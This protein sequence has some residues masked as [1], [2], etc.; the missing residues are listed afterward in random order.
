MLLLLPQ[1]MRADAMDDLLNFFYTYAVPLPPEESGLDPEW[2]SPYSGLMVQGRME[3]TSVAGAPL[4][5]KLSAANNGNVFKLDPAG[6]LVGIAQDGTKNNVKTVDG[7]VTRVNNS[8][9]DAVWVRWEDCKMDVKLCQELYDLPLRVQIDTS[10]EPENPTEEIWLQPGQ[11][12]N[13]ENN[14][15]EAGQN[16]LDVRPHIQQGQ[17]IINRTGYNAVYNV[18]STH[19]SPAIPK[20]YALGGGTFQ[21]DWTVLGHWVGIGRGVMV[22]LI[23][24]YTYLSAKQMIADAI[25][26]HKMSESARTTKISTSAL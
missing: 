14:A 18:G 5:V 11:G 2:V 8:M 7:S 6:N 22:G 1:V 3:V 25:S 24:L 12:I 17:Q 20:P 4:E 16:I 21:L 9:A 23:G 26:H 13:T 15:T 19:L 10:N